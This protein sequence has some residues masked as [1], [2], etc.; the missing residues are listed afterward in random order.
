[1]D[2]GKWISTWFSILFYRES[3]ATRTNLGVPDWSAGCCAY[4]TSPETIIYGQPVYCMTKLF[5]LTLLAL[6][7][8][9]NAAADRPNIVL[10]LADDLGYEGLS[11]NGGRSFQ[12][13]SFDRLARQGMRFTH[14]YSQPICTPSRNK[15]M[16]G[17][18]NARNCGCWPG[19]KARL[20]RRASVM[21]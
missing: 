8:S 15:I 11:C 16:T 4:T 18:S 3:S 5:T 21:T 1:M 12:S 10:I 2:S 17:R 6:F 7:I 9:A 13:P 14:C 20:L 19:G